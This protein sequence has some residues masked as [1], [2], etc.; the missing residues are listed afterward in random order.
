[1][2]NIGKLYHVKGNRF[3]LFP[4]LIYMG[5]LLYHA[6]PARWHFYSWQFFGAS[7]RDSSLR[8]SLPLWKRRIP[9]QTVSNEQDVRVSYTDY[10]SWWISWDC[11]RA[12]KTTTKKNPVNFLS[13]APWFPSHV[14]MWCL[15]D[16][17]IIRWC[18][19]I[20]SNLGNLMYKES[21]LTWYIIWLLKF[22]KRENI[23][24]LAGLLTWVKY[25]LIFSVCLSVYL[26]LPPLKLIYWLFVAKI[27]EQKQKYAGL[28]Q[29]L[30]VT[31]NT[32]TTTTTTFMRLMTIS[33]TVI[34]AEL[35][36][37][38]FAWKRDPPR[39]LAGCFVFPE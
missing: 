16:V 31:L 13:K 12:C 15:C 5:H 23:Y 2:D 34:V 14:F 20:R 17:I 32:N 4:E 11:L 24:Q 18:K 27:Y 6:S 30:S 38:L 21:T 28:K 3:Q 22:H 39:L 9:R 10:S 1:M 33:F 7:D 37:S 26:F 36:V 29:V 19:F 25:Q 35:F 8:S